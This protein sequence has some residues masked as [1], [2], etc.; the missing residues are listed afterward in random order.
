[1]LA[2]AG[3]AALA[4]SDQGDTPVVAEEMAQMDADNVVYGMSQIITRQGMREAVVEADT[5]FFYQDSS[6]VHLRGVE[7]TFFR[8]E[9]AERARVVAQR[10]RLDTTAEEM[11]GRGDVV[12]TI[13]GEN[14][15]IETDELHYSSGEDR[16]WSETYTVMEEGGERTCGTSFRSDLE[17]RNVVIDNARTANCQRSP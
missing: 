17:F 7:M 10:G 15:R 3:L 13:R 8:E 11:V 14:R 9:G 1:M 16:I 4:C 5:A 12:L 2:L 6:A